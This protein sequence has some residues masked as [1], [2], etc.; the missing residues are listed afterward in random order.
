MIIGV[1]PCCLRTITVERNDPH[2]IHFNVRDKET[3]V[4]ITCPKLE[5]DTP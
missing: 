5:G 3:E 2:K 4:V 1:C